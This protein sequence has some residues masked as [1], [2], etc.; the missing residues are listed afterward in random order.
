[1]ARCRWSQAE[2]AMPPVNVVV[3]D[4]GAQDM[5]ELSAAYD[6][7]PVEAVSAD[8]ADPTLGE[9]VR[10]RRAKGCADDLDGLALEDLVEGTAELAVAVVNQEP[11]R[12]RALCD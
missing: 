12:S 5:F 3:V 4:V 6:Q 1:M 11:N 9:R 7:E 10:V 2:R 8:G